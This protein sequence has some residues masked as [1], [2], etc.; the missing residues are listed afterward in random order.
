MKELFGAKELHVMERPDEPGR[1]QHAQVD[2]GG[3]VIM[4]ADT[5]E[6]YPVQ[7]AGLFIYLPDTDATYKLAMERGCKSAMEPVKT[8]YADRAAGILDPFGNT[9]WLATVA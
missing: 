7:N 2:I 4:F 5:V 1:I 6:L 3:S 9:W 8:S